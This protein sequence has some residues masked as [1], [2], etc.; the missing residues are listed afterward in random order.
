MLNKQN[1]QRA[2]Q[3]GEC[4]E[5]EM[6]RAGMLNKQN[7]QRDIKKWRMCR[8]GM[9]N[10]Q[11]FLLDFFQEDAMLCIFHFSFIDQ[12]VNSLIGCFVDL[13]SF[14]LLSSFIVSLIL[15]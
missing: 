9:L 1:N 14:S 13:I 2:I 7:I 15:C 8:S 4:V 12:L 5:L 11:M 3:N 10:K 6:C